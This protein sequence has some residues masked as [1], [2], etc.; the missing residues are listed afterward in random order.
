MLTFKKE[1]GKGGFGVVNLMHDQINN[2]DVAVKIVS[3]K[4]GPIDSQMM[5]K[6]VIALSNLHHKNIVKLMDS[7]S[8]KEQLIVIMEYLEGGELLEYWKRFP[9]RRMPEKEAC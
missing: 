2:S 3:N 5:K 7:F 4:N 9:N 1:L 8:I 6:E